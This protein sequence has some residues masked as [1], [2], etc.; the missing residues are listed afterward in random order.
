MKKYKYLY[1]KLKDRLFLTRVINRHSRPV[2][3]GESEFDHIYLEHYINDYNTIITTVKTEA[4]DDSEIMNV[5]MR[6][7]FHYE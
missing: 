7:C 6:F 4:K 2:F 5:S 1:V 3:E